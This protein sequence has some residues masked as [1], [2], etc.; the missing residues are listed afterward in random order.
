MKNKAYKQDKTERNAA[1]NLLESELQTKDLNEPPERKRAIYNAFEA[2]DARFDGQI[3]AAVSSTGIYC[4][5]VCPYHAKIEN[6]TFYTSA[7]EAESAGYRPCLVC[8][9]ETAPGLSSADAKLNLARRTVSI[10]KKECT[11]GNG[12]EK[13]AAKLGYTDRHVRRIFE[14]EYGITPMQFLTTCR[15]SL[16]KSLLADTD[17]P[18]SQ[19]ALAA[20]FKSTRRFNDTFK[21]HYGL[22]PSEQ[23]RLSKSKTSAGKTKSSDGTKIK[24]STS[25]KE[26]LTE[27]H[28]TAKT[29]YPQK[30]TS[31]IKLKLG[32]RP[33]YPF[34]E[35]LSFFRS[36]AI[37]GIEAIDETS[38]SRTACVRLDHE[39]LYGWI[40]IE[41][42]SKHNALILSISEEL[43]PATSIVVARVRQM[44]DLDCNPE[45]IYENL[46]TLEHMYP[47]TIVRGTRLPGCFEPFE[48]CCRAVLGQQVSI[49]AANKLAFRIAQKLGKQLDT[50]VEGLNYSWPKPE[51]FLALDDPAGVLG[52]LGVV[53]SRTHAICEI[54]RMIT[55]GE[56]CFDTFADANEQMK[57]LQ[58]I[59][60]IGPWTANYVAMRVL[61]YPDAFLEKD[62]GVIH[63]LPN[64]TPKERIELVEPC[65]PWRSYAVINLWNSLAKKEAAAAK[66]KAEEAAKKA[67]EK[68]AERAAKKKAAKKK[69]SKTKTTQNKT[70]SANAKQTAKQTNTKQAKTK[71]P[72]KDAA[73]KKEQK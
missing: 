29:P 72:P 68:K 57:T 66:K 44:F 67:A 28:S 32:Y 62:I 3:F 49:A 25:A 51:E 14:D 36:R 69:V 26:T 56:L 21:N 46:M 53:R 65:R 2:K 40:H 24:T 64:T 33:P 18:I 55:T 54:A 43:L 70:K 4:R 9:P 37:V 6:I 60:G 58:S 10:I 59:K 20:G 27:K 31:T 50:G 38:Y 30:N 71:M 16:A 11:T 7:A 63:A 73:D 23:R 41:N 19:V 52:P 48:T 61:S 34:E 39:E 45:A 8:R 17:L 1:V 15:C 42:D 35:L 22:T 13:I 47:N 5:P 12:L